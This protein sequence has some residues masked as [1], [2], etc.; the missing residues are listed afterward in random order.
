MKNNA[1]FIEEMY[2]GFQVVVMIILLN[3]AFPL[4]GKGQ[5]ILLKGLSLCYVLYM[6]YRIYTYYRSSFDDQDRETSNNILYIG[7]IDGLFLSFFVFIK[8]QSDMPLSN[9]IM[10]YV[11]IQTIRLPDKGKRYFYIIALLLEGYM[12]YISERTMYHILDLASNVLFMFF[13]SISV[14]MVLKEIMKLQQE[15]AYYVGELMETNDKL[16]LLANTDYLTGLYNH[17]AFYLEINNYETH[18]M[19]LAIIDIDNF[20][21]VN[22][23]YGHLVGDAIL[24]GLA[25]LMTNNVRKTDFVARYGGEE[26]VIIFPNVTIEEGTELCERLR[27]VVENHKFHI[28]GHD[29]S[30]TIS[31][32][33]SQLKVYNQDII[34]DFIKSVD[35]LLYTAKNG[36]KNCVVSSI[37]EVSQIQ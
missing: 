24:T 4:F 5:D 30:I 31:T 11:L 16:N 37:Y 8:G 9:I 20:K 17:K 22:D 1:G 26:F 10:G 18:D 23:T 14:G 36:G 21:V 2:L 27:K 25:A 15:N 12:F 3:M 29:L 33:V 32:G 19:C 35:E 13:I 6:G 7:L 28:D 34:P